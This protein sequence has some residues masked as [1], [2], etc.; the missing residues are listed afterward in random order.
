LFEEMVK[1]E[2]DDHL[3]LFFFQHHLLEIYQE[4][5]FSTATE[6]KWHLPHS[7]KIELKY[8]L[9]QKVLIEKQKTRI[10]KELDK[11]ELRSRETLEMEKF[12]T[13]LFKQGKDESVV[14][15]MIEKTF[16]YQLQSQVRM[17]EFYGMLVPGLRKLELTQNAT[18]RV[19]TLWKP[20]IKMYKDYLKRLD[21]LA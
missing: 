16:P 15:S 9:D 18:R 6:K 8:L 10:Q 5:L 19:E 3:E 12:A 11:L 4:L 17:S 20:M 2:N 13:N 21:E 14:I 7:L 1:I